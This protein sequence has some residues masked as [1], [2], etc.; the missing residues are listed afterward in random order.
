MKFGLTESEYEYIDKNVAK[1]LK[2]L[3]ASLFC[4]GSRAR[5]DHK[6]FSDLDL[7]IETASS[8]NLREMKSLIE[9]KLSAGNF[10]YKVDLVFLDELASTYRESYEQDK[11]RW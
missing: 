7:M 2:K 5:G 10:P 8:Q 1:P 6:K 9:E 4:F 3:N 11:T